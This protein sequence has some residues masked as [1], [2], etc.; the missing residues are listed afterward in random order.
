VGKTRNINI[1][2]TTFVPTTM[3][4]K[5]LWLAPLAAAVIGKKKK[6]WSF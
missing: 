6:G 4:A 1:L 2:K 5:A 3:K